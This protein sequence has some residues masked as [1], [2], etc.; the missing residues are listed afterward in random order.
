[1][2]DS[3]V[4]I[5]LVAVV[6]ELAVPESLDAAVDKVPAAVPAAV[7]ADIDRAHAVVVLMV[8]KNHLIPVSPV[9]LD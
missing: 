6:H 1:V 7:V 3:A 4:Q 9:D 8:V 5:R 2:A